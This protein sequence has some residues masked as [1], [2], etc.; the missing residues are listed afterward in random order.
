MRTFQIPRVASLVALTVVLAFDACSG[1]GSQ[2]SGQAGSTGAAGTSAGG[3]TGTTGGTTGSAGSPGAAGATATGGTPGTGGTSAIAG[4]TG[5][6]GTTGTAGT[7]GSAGTTGAAGTTGVAGTTGAGGAA[8]GGTSGLTTKDF[9]CNEIIG[10]EVSSVWFP[11][12]E[13]G[14]D[15]AKW[16]MT[17]QHH[18]YLEMFADPA[19]TYWSNALISAC[20]MNS[21]TPD[22]VIFLPYSLTLNT[23]DQWLMN[24][25]KVVETMKGKFPGVKRIELMTTLRSPGNMACAND[26]DP[27]GTLVAPYVDQA[28]QMVADGSGGL[29]TVGPKIEVGNCNWWTTGA[30]LTTA[31]F[32]G[33][34]MLYATYYT[35][36]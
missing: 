30:Q 27:L 35:T 29:V 11:T 31:G 33:A 25:K 4:T 28:I 6:A 7:T 17:F 9:V 19:S 16:Q 32:A 12:F 3:T 36:H 21:K 8:A 1:G 34:G 26:P 20:T 15:N 24:L 22:R 14:V 13:M 10:L 18:G 23:L 5:N 2:P